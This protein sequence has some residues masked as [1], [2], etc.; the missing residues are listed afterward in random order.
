MNHISY[1]LDI[2]VSMPIDPKITGCDELIAM[3]PHLNI[4]C[5]GCSVDDRY[6]ASMQLVDKNGKLIKEWIL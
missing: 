2:T 4:N 3:L 6:L 1:F 5:N